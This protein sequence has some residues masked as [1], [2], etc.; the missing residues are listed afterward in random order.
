MYFRCEVVDVV[1]LRQAS[2]NLLLSMIGLPLH[3]LNQPL[4]GM[5]TVCGYIIVVQVL[6]GLVV[7]AVLGRWPLRGVTKASTGTRATTLLVEMVTFCPKSS[8]C[9][10]VPLK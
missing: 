10:E 8:H 7:V 1:E 5:D 4:P 2:I 3:F 9:N 6:G